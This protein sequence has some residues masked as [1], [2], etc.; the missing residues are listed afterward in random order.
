M[1]EQLNMK[2]IFMH[3]GGCSSMKMI[4]EIKHHLKLPFDV[5]MGVKSETTSLVY[6]IREATESMLGTVF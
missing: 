6:I 3:G 2:I 5:K 4:I 1:D